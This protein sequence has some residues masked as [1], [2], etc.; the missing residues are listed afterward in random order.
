MKHRDIV[1]QIF[2]STCLKKIGINSNDIDKFYQGV[3]EVLVR[4]DKMKK[5]IGE[6]MDIVFGKLCIIPDSGLLK[7]YGLV[8][9]LQAMYINK[10]GELSDNDINYNYESEGKYTSDYKKAAENIIHLLTLRKDR[11]LD[12]PYREFVEAAMKTT[13]SK[14]HRQKRARWFLRALQNKM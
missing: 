10:W 12:E 8:S 9:L 2:A 1:A 13:D 4:K 14:D 7:G 11:V 3:D 5:R 6:M